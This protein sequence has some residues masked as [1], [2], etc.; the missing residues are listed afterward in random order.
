MVEPLTVEAREAV[1]LAPYAMHSAASAGRKHAEPPH[2]YR[3]PFQRDRD[4]I[5]HSAAFRRLSSKTQVFTGEGG[6]YHRTR[7]THTLEVASIART[8]ARALRLNEDLVESLALAHDLGHPPFGHAGEEVLHACLADVGGFSHNQQGLRIVEE[9]EQRYPDF[10]GLNLTLEVLEGQATR[11]THDVSARR[12]LVEVQVVD[13]ADSIAYDTHDVDDA[14]Q[15]GLL[16]IGELLAV[17]LWREAAER[18]RQ[19]WPEL[20]ESQTKRAVLHELIDWQVSDL[21]DQVNRRIA[22]ANIDSVAAVRKA[23]LIVEPSESLAA[24]KTQLE[25][26]L[27]DRV[28]RHPQVL[29]LRRQVQNELSQM[30]E[31]YRA[32]PDLLPAGFRSRVDQHGLSRT[33]GDYLAG[34][35]DRYARS[36]YL[37]LFAKQ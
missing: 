6:D 30:F 33:V 1:L 29:R 28:Y 9:I 36:E 20:G 22:A 17:P 14:L 7:L 10:P 26:F 23:P 24:K 11:I 16:T 32:R 8:L 25:S 18:V 19:R 4:R 13:A 34:M 31:G 15:M 37:R 3:G 27:R 12:P 2:P 35:T 21:L 5:V